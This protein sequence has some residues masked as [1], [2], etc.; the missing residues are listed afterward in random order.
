M[1]T[2]TRYSYLSLLEQ[3][4]IEFDRYCYIDFKLCVRISTF[5]R[6]FFFSSFSLSLSRSLYLSRALVR[7]LAPST[8]VYVYLTR[9]HFAVTVGNE[10]VTRL[11]DGTVGRPRALLPER[12][13]NFLSVISLRA[14]F[15]WRLGPRYVCLIPRAAG[16][17]RARWHAQLSPRRRRRRW[18][19]PR[20]QDRIY[21]PWC[22]VVVFPGSRTALL[23][24]VTR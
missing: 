2:D 22:P 13:C 20:Q 15:A 12:R 5:S 10:E 24:R 19:P 9:M 23:S 14:A 17:R 4:K 18:Q 16:R 7:S 21:R 3:R 11:D 6:I 8:Y 1:I